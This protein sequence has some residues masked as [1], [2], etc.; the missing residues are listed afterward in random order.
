VLSLWSDKQ[1]AQRTWTPPAGTV[2]RSDLNA[3]G[4]GAVSTMLADSNGPVAGGTVGG[5]TASVPTSSNRATVFT[6]VLTAG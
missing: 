3:P 1:S 2:E 5:V 4:T 6:L